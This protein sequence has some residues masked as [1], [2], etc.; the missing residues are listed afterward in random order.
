[1][2]QSELDGRRINVELTAG[3]G[4]K[5]DARLTKLKA[6]NKE[7]STQ[8]VRFSSLLL[9]ATLPTGCHFVDATVTQGG[10][11]ARR[12]HGATGEFA[13]TTFLD[14]IR[15]GRCAAREAYLDSER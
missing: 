1:L 12:E 7:L 3:G 6:R 2:H 11:R 8:R 10:F 9:L 4:G 13:A 14:D 5:G 15:G